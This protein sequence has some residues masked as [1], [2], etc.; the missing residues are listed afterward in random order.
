MIEAPGS[1]FADVLRIMTGEP[2]MQ[3]LTP[4][5]GGPAFRLKRQNGYFVDIRP[6]LF[7]IRVALTPEACPVVYD[8][9]FCYTGTSNQTFT[10]AVLAAAQ[11][12]VRDDT[13]P[14][15]WNK[16]GQT[17]EYREPKP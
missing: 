2:I 4:D 14:E 7:N 3:W 16:N 1:P 6:M 11:W 10:A 17:G 15:G 9:H 12:D 13:E 8:R 5:E